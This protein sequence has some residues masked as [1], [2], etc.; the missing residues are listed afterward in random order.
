MVRWIA[1]IL[2]GALLG[3]MVGC[4]GGGSSDDAP[5]ST[6]VSET[7]PSRSPCV[8]APDGQ[9]VKI[10]LGGGIALDA[11][12]LGDGETGVVLGHQLRRD[13]C[14]WAPFARKLAERGDM[15]VLAI[16]F[17]STSPDSDMEAAAG[18]LRRRG[19]KRVLLV[20]A[21]MG[22]TAAL[23]AATRVDADG[24]AA[25][26]AP[27]QFGDLDAL[28]AVRDL[29]APTLY[30]VGRQDQAFATDARLLHR[31]TRTRDKAL[32]VLPGAAHGTDL[33]DNPRAERALLAFL[34][35]R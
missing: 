5:G 28:P 7:S 13:F 27:R 10:D 18:E 15:T 33:L 25:L 19:S 6:T 34:A 1:R 11:L 4:G 30:L 14:S 12:L 35:P 17:G 9:G 24:V 21:S 22:G 31:A 20:G 29:E 16:N 2:L 26:S 8:E 23:A 3:T 32:L